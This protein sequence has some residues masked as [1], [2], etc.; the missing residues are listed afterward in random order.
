M[1]QQ[2]LVAITFTKA[3][4]VSSNATTLSVCMQ[5]WMRG[6]GQMGAGQQPEIDVAHISAWSWCM[7]AAVALAAVLCDASQYLVITVRNKLAYSQYIHSPL[8]GEI[9]S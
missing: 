4:C 2:N 1:I 7:V 9:Q 6:A 5:W 8:R 3:W